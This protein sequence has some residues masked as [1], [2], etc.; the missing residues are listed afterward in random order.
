MNCVAQRQI[1]LWQWSSLDVFE[2]FRFIIEQIRTRGTIVLPYAV[3]MK[4]LLYNESRYFNGLLHPEQRPD[5]ASR[6]GR[7]DITAATQPT[8]ESTSTVSSGRAPA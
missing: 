8:I 4:S 3:H 5:Q 1:A 6:Q 7:H 2:P